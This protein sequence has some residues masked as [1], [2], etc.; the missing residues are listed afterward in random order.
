MGDVTMLS[1]HPD[2][3]PGRA[4][5]SV[6]VD[7]VR[8]DDDAFTQLRGYSG[9]Q[10]GEGVSSQVSSEVI[11]ATRYL[12]VHVAPGRSAQGARVSSGHRSSVSAVSPA[13]IAAA[14]LHTASIISRSRAIASF[15][16]ARISSS[17]S[18]LV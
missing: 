15:S 7:V 11:P 5:H 8:P 18:G 10:V 4:P 1:H 6:A 2:R 17:R 16:T 14:A 12:L 9:N 13:S 3:K